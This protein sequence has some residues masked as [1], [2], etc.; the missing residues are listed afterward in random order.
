MV[1]FIYTVANMT[2]GGY[3]KKP[4][5]VDMMHAAVA[6]MM[7]ASDKMKNVHIMIFMQIKIDYNVWQPYW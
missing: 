7:K 2:H 4:L 3:F 6:D 1:D 5:L